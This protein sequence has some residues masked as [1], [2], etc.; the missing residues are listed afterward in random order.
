MIKWV[1]FVAFFFAFTKVQGQL[2]YTI[3]PKNGGTVSYLYGTIHMMPEDQFKLS[4]PL[5]SAFDACGTLAM[6]VDL[7]LDL[8][9]KIEIAKQT[10]LPD[11]KTLKDIT[12]PE[13]YSHIERYCLDSCGMSKKKLK[14]YSRLKPFF[15]SSAMLQDQLK[16]TKSYELEFQKMAEK[17]KKSTMGLESIQVQMETISSVSLEDQVSMLLDGINQPQQYQGMLQ[18]YLAE[19]LDGLYKDIVAESEGFPN[20]IEDFLNRRN[21][22]WIPVISAQVERGAT[23]IAV[24]AGHLPGGEGVINLLRNAGYRVSPLEQMK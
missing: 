21:R 13:E 6:E 12:T 24:G 18:A 1:S 19:D 14:R 4:P 23:F 15:F 2:L 22:N 7:N 9:E 3:Q 10:I 17:G 5:V 11:G 20:F 8:A 16:D